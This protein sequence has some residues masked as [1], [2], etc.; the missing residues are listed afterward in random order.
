MYI[1][2]EDELLAIAK[3]FTQHLHQAEYVR[4]KKE[5]L[6]REGSGVD[7]LSRPTDVRA[8]M[9]EELRKR[10]DAQAR[11]KTQKGKVDALMK[12]LRDAPDAVQAPATDDEEDRD[13]DP[14]VG[15]SL[16]GLMSDVR[17]PRPS[18]AKLADLKSTSRAAAGLSRADSTLSGSTQPTVVRPKTAPVHPTQARSVDRESTS[19]TESDDDLGR[20]PRTTR[21]RS[22]AGRSTLSSPKGPSRLKGTTLHG[23]IT[24]DTR[25]SPDG[26]SV[27]ARRDPPRPDN[28]KIVAEPPLCAVHS[29]SKPTGVK[30][31]KSDLDSAFPDYNI[32]PTALSH[33]RSRF[34][35]KMAVANGPNDAGKEGGAKKATRN[36]NEI[37]TF[38]V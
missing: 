17:D 38:L 12:G 33:R 29:A 24:D 15:T 7:R 11:A 19:T 30:G 35:Q 14:W 8:V 4:L 18:L 1:M 2:V 22:K 31:A 32:Q 28:K 3:E 9:S 13:D 27:S 34:R 20:P 36:L 23:R 25:I 26:A 21:E 37:P 10:K 16:Q 5:A 6:A